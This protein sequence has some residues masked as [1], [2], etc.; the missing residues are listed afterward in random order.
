MFEVGWVYRTSDY[1]VVEA[2]DK[3]AVRKALE[4]GTID[5][6]HYDRPGKNRGG[7]TFVGEVI[8]EDGPDMVIDAEGGEVI[9]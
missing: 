4:L 3:E 1:C 8:Y 2:P 6:E 9:R 7:E 5:Y